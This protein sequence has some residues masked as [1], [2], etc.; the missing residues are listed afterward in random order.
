MK[1]EQHSDAAGGKSIETKEKPLF[2]PVVRSLVYSLRSPKTLV[3][4][5]GKKGRRDI[6]EWHIPIKSKKS[7]QAR[8]LAELAGGNIKP[9]EEIAVAA[10][11]EVEEELNLRHHCGQPEKIGEISYEIPRYKKTTPHR[12]AHFAG[13][14]AFGLDRPYPIDPDQAKIDRVVSLT[15][16][17][18]KQLL[19]TGKTEIEQAGKK[20]E[21]INAID[22]LHLGSQNNVFNDQDER[23]SLYQHLINFIDSKEEEARQGLSLNTVEDI[24]SLTLITAQK[25]LDGFKHRGDY[26]FAPAMMYALCGWG[27]AFK[28]DSNSRDELI[29]LLPKEEGEKFKN[30]F[31]ILEDAYTETNQQSFVN[32]KDENECFETKV[33][34]KLRRI[35]LLIGPQQLN[36]HLTRSMKFINLISEALVS[37]GATKGE[38]ISLTNEVNNQSLYFLYEILRDK[39]LYKE[40]INDRIFYDAAKIIG[41]TYSLMRVEPF[42]LA[43]KNRGDLEID[44][45]ITQLF[46]QTNQQVMVGDEIATVRKFNLFEEEEDATETADLRSIAVIIDE[47]SIKDRISFH[48]KVLTREK[49]QDIGDI[50]RRSIVVVGFYDQ[51][52]QLVLLKDNDSDQLNEKLLITRIFYTNLQKKLSKVYGLVIGS[53][54]REPDKDITNNLS[55]SSKNQEKPN[56]G[57]K[58]NRF[59][60]IKGYVFSEGG[61]DDREISELAIWA[62]TGKAMINNEEYFGYAHKK[63]DDRLYGFWRLAKFLGW[64]HPDTIYK[65]A[66]TQVVYASGKR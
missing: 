54:K 16:T 40:A 1:L 56:I 7:E 4:E 61:G 5:L 33:E 57:S 20:P 23:Q 13:I 28:P 44:R 43:A 19:T 14:Q 18:L 58:S 27:Q 17:Q 8:G 6:F 2:L 10:I 36:D 12:Q 39:R 51:D 26:V 34:E 22:Y 3:S 66:V 63:I 29:D 65:E 64:F 41:A 38:D 52:N 55:F 53:S 42:Y 11:R 50:F 48:R 9:N 60:W 21:T 30:F 31:T 46:K 35:G 15:S 45:A 59:L 32:L 62:A 47:A 24:K 37:K 49:P 25:Y